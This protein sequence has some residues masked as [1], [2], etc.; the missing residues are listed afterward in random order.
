M[1][2]YGFAHQAINGVSFVGHNGGTLGYEGQIDIYTKLGYVAVILTNQDQVLVPAIRRS[3][4]LL[5][6][7]M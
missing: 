5:T 7:S 2:T 1:Y 6:Q 4:G 3:E